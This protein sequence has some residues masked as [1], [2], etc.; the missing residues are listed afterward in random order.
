MDFCFRK[1]KCIN[2]LNR[3]AVEILIRNPAHESTMFYT[4]YGVYLQII[5][6]RIF[7]ASHFIWLWGVGDCL[8]VIFLLYNLFYEIN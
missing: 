7:N 6:T 4:S 3:L 1:G 8:D 5:G 2:N